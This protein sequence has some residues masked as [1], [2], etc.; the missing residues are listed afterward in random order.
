MSFNQIDA[1]VIIATYNEAENISP[2]IQSILQNVVLTNII[3]IDDN[4]PDGTAKIVRKLKNNDR[5]ILRVR[6]KNKG[7]APSILEGFEIA[8]ELGAKKIITMDADFSHDPSEI[9]NILTALRNNDVVIGSRYIGGIRILN[10]KMDRLLLSFFANHYIRFFS[11]MPF[12]DCTSGFRGYSR[13][14]IEK[15]VKGQTFR[16]S[17]Y[18]FLVEVLFSIH[19]K[20]FIIKEIPIIYSERRVGQSKMKKKMILEAAL[21]P[22]TLLFKKR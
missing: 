1:A 7:Y 11:R 9:P 5:I 22:I 18:A 19:R 6:K 14:V 20:N 15:V 13:K 8:F 2:I 3:I 16:S 21:L 17:G 12:Y 10:W 4:S